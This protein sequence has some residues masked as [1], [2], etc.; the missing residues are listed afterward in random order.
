MYNRAGRY[1]WEASCLQ[2]TFMWTSILI[3]YVL[4]WLSGCNWNRVKIQTKEI[5]RKHVT[6]IKTMGS[7]DVLYYECIHNTHNMKTYIHT[8]QNVQ[9]HTCI[10]VYIILLKICATDWGDILRGDAL[11]LRVSFQGIIGFGIGLAAMVRLL[12]C[13]GCN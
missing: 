9:I 10:H 12:F 8:M 5:Y 3:F 2:H 13:D 7:L 4:L 6:Y 11:N 1:I